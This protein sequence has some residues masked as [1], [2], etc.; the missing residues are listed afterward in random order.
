VLTAEKPFL[1]AVAE[2]VKT[3]ANAAENIADELGTT[4]IKHNNK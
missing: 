1:V 3:K 4:D 2:F